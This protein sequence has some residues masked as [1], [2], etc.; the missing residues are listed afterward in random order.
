MLKNR[1]CSWCDNTGITDKGF[2]H[3]CK[4]KGYTEVIE[5]AEVILRQPTVNL[6]DLLH[7]VSKHTS[8]EQFNNIMNDYLSA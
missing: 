4:G 7:F 2:C 8:T 6:A 5:K 3:M 1:S